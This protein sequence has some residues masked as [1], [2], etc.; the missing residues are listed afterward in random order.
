M[1]IFMKHWAKEKVKW[2][3]EKQKPKSYLLSLLVVRAAEEFPSSEN[4]TN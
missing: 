4:S 3:N 2:H 1:I